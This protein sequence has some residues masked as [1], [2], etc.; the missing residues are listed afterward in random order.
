MVWSVS[1]ASVDV[2]IECPLVRAMSPVVDY[3]CAASISLY[4]SGF[5]FCF[6]EDKNFEGRGHVVHVSNLRDVVLKGTDKIIP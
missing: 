2:F 3:L 5:V 6:L 1:V 4:A